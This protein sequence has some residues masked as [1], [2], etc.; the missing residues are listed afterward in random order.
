MVDKKIEVKSEKQELMLEPMKATYYPQG[1]LFLRVGLADGKLEDGTKFDVASSGGSIILN[2]TNK[3]A[4][5][6]SD[7]WALT[8]NEIVN[9]VLKARDVAM[10]K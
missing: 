3:E 9:A 8:L 2:F 4:K 6:G 1:A 7:T 10:K 5:F